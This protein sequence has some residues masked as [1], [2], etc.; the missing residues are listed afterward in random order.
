MKII[1]Q[2]WR[3]LQKPS[4]PLIALES[5]GRVCYK[6]EDKIEPGS[7]AKF[8]KGIVKKGHESVIEH[9][10]AS[11]VIITSRS[12]THELVRHRLA[13]FSQESQRYVKYGDNMEFIKPVWWDEWSDHEQKVWEHS[14]ASD[15]E[16]YKELID[17][18]SRP[19]QA[20]E[21]LP[22]ALKTEIV[23]TANLREWRHIFKM[24]C[25]KAA[26]PQ[27]RELFK[28]VLVGFHAAVPVVF[29]DLAE[30]FL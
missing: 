6:S 17:A 24:R 20:R 14:M 16:A 30:Q 10:A 21:V 25:Q 19:E 22:N 12:V 4:S 13:S 23:A 5:A 15:A 27:I 11:V 3:W 18:G 9:C 7:A 1:N 2:S 28:G 29:D 26:H 8:I